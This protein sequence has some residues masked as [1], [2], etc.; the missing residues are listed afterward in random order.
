[1]YLITTGES[2]EDDSER[3]GTEGS[4]LS[5]LMLL[6]DAANFIASGYAFK[7]LFGGCLMDVLYCLHYFLSTTNMH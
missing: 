1:M 2:R 3:P 7:M 6:L 5:L 4:L